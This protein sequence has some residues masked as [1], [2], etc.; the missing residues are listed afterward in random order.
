MCLFFSF[1]YETRLCDEIAVFFHWIMI[2]FSVYHVWIIA[3][4]NAKTNKIKLTR[5]SS[6]IISA[7]PGL[8]SMSSVFERDVNGSTVGCDDI[9]NSVVP[10]VV[11][12]RPPAVDDGEI[13]FR[14]FGVADVDCAA[15]VFIENSLAVAVSEVLAF[16]GL[17]FDNAPKHFVLFLLNSLCGKRSIT[18]RN[19][20]NAGNFLKCTKFANL[21]MVEL[22]SWKIELKNCREKKALKRLFN[23][24]DIWSARR[25]N[26]QQFKHCY[27]QMYICKSRAKDFSGKLIVVGTQFYFCL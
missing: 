3:E 12:W 4:S 7:I 10:M 25:T 5:S 11:P 8:I 16:H 22:V 13:L 15:F 2:P 6:R 19:K 20:N 23:F 26:F 27:L 17:N 18:A 24:S 9:G 14:I 1:I 21:E